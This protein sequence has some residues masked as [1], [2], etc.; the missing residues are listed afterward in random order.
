M[1]FSLWVLLG[2]HVMHRIAYVGTDELPFLQ[3]TSDMGERA[4]R[5]S[6]MSLR[7]IQ[8]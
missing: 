5:S 6:H 8:R 7:N 4:C 1:G 2:A 3:T